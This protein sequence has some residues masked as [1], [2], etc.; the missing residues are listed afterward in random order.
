M[1]ERRWSRRPS[2]DPQNEQTL[3]SPQPKKRFNEQNLSPQSSALS[4]QPEKRYMSSS[5]RAS[6]LPPMVSVSQESGSSADHSGETV[7]EVDLAYNTSHH[8]HKG[9]RKVSMSVESTRRRLS[10]I[11]HP[12]T[13][14]RERSPSPFRLGRRGS[15]SPYRSREWETEEKVSGFGKQRRSSGVAQQQ[16]QQ[17]QQR[18]STRKR[19]QWARSVR[20]KTMS[21]RS[22]LFLSVE[23]E[24]F[25]VHPLL[26][27]ARSTS[28]RPSI[29]G[30]SSRS[31][32]T[33]SHT[34]S[35]PHILLF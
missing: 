11:N 28:P 8:S 27:S 9:K 14:S 30:S 17:Q 15:R 25:P 7:L 6:A 3:S 5:R 1:V 23:S 34:I 13:L 26:R 35:H 32:S 21:A 18:T 2:Y 19:E 12:T 33:C 31:S 4:P 24:A 22:S 29:S 10:A 20:A 16:Q